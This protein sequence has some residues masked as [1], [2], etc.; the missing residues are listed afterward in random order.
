MKKSASPK[1]CVFI[2]DSFWLNNSFFPFYLY[3]E[4]N[5]IFNSYIFLAFLCRTFCF[6][7]I[8]FFF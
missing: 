4:I 2:E 5:L 1:C 8:N 3:T 6:L 7:E